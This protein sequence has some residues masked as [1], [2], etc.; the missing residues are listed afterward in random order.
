MGE[1]ILVVLGILIALQINDWNENKKINI[2]EA[3]TLKN[4][5]SELE[6]S[7]QELR[8][9]YGRIQD[10]QKSTLNIYKYI[11]KKPILN[12][13]MYLDFYN[14]IQFSFFFPKTSTYETLKSGNLELIKSDSL[15]IIITDIYEAGYK[16]ILTKVSTRRNAANIL[17]PYYQENFRTKLIP[18]ISESTGYTRVAI[19]NDYEYLINDSKYESLISEAVL[20][21]NMEVDDFRRTI[22]F[23]VKGIEGIDEYLKTN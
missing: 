19:P 16:R 13:S 17:F 14:S 3:V 6:S 18:N 10:Y 12:D 1:I 11:Q 8:T 2:K 9:D 23:V 20:G 5:K 15:R 22:E 7:L 21:R 4:L